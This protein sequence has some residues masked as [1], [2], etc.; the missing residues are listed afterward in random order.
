MKITLNELNFIVRE[1]LSILK[2]NME[3]EGG[4][5]IASSEPIRGDVAG[6]VA[7]QIIDVL[8]KGLGIECR[9]LG[10]TGKKRA[11]QTSGDIDI[12][13]PMSWDDKNKLVLFIRQTYGKLEDFCNNAFKI[14]SI[15][16][17]YTDNIE[18]KIV[19]VD[20]MFGQNLDYSS[21]IHHSPDYTKNES[22]F[23][24][25]IRT[26]LLRILAN[27]VPVNE[28]EY[29]STYYDETDFGGLY[30]GEKE[31]WWRYSIDDELGLIITHRTNRGKRKPL[32]RS[33]RF[34]E[35]TKVIT[36]DINEIL[37]IVLGP[38]ATEQDCNSFESMVDFL[39]SGKYRYASPEQMENIMAKFMK[40][41]AVNKD[42]EV[43]EKI[44][45]I[46]SGRMNYV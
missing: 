35:D 1:T 44:R 23:K 11:D 24:G 39:F 3:I 2:E 45:Q 12:A 8:K 4:N 38:G 29:P 13:V 6:E 17:P 16:F 41:K 15:G 19:Q 46:L 34:P 26:E 28:K 40:N 18:H 30:K 33:T 20:F 31:T 43:K 22:E 37:K 42:P 10:S 14:Y 9:P 27:L 5:A 36:S 32:A 7:R 25:A 21:F